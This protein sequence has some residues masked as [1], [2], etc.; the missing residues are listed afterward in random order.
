[1]LRMLY[2]C[3]F[4]TAILFAVFCCM[5]QSGCVGGGGGARLVT[6]KETDASETTRLPRQLHQLLVQQR[7]TQTKGLR[8]PTSKKHHSCTQGF[9]SFCSNKTEQRLPV[10]P[11]PTTFIHFHF[12]TVKYFSHCSVCTVLIPK[13]MAFNTSIIL[14]FFC[15]MAVGRGSSGTPQPWVQK[16]VGI[17]NE[18]L[19]FRRFKQQSSAFFTH[20]PEFSWHIRTCNSS[21]SVVTLA[22]FM[23]GTSTVR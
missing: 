18:W 5:A 22:H 10:K 15:F 23:R 20:W 11:L 1:M 17:Q 19:Y 6:A 9:Y 4:F 13:N 12:I 2:E 14:G 3:V 8:P 16:G 21:F 7:S